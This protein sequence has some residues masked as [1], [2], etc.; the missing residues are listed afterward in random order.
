MNRREFA[1]T[2]VVPALWT[3]EASWALSLS[4]GDAA[5]GIRAALER[6]AISAVGLLGRNDGFLANPKVRIP[7]PGFL[8]DAAKILK[9]TGQGKRV[10]ELVTAMNRAAEAAVPE[11][12]SLLVNAAKSITL[13]DALRIVKGGDTS[14]TDYF[15]SKTRE[16]LG[17]KFLPIVTQATEKVALADKYNAVAGKAAGLG[18]LKTKDANLQ[19]YVT[20]KALDGLY[21]MIG[22][23]EK[24]IRR[25]PVGTGSAI[26]RKV[27]GG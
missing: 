7:L 20:G 14:V 4:E 3:A 2:L 5:A 27:F 24:K 16:P 8:N 21:F 10:D 13:E 25:D 22:E 12:K 19:Q 15:S 18:L 6:G 23:E 1:C 11:A 9:A 26:L 17:V